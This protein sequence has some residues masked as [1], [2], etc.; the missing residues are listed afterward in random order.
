MEEKQKKSHYLDDELLTK[1]SK[2]RKLEQCRSA[3][4]TLIELDMW[5]LKY[6]FDELRNDKE[7]VL[8]AVQKD[9]S[10]LVY[11]SEYIRDDIDVVL[12]AVH[13]WASALQYASDELKNNKDVVL[14]AVQKGGY[15]LG[16]D[17]M[18]LVYYLSSR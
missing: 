7:I 3:I 5:K 6:G 2:K 8:K 13:Q 15:S 10:A 16:F 1:P 11:A 9:G 14:K 17:G 18:L 4:L 12:A